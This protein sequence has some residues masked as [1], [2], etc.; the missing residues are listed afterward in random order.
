MVEVLV[1]LVIT[2]ILM[3][4]LIPVIGKAKNTAK[5]QSAVQNLRQLSVNLDL[6]RS[7]WNGSE[8][9]F[10]SYYSLGLPPVNYVRGEFS[11]IN[12]AILPSPCGLN[13]TAFNT[14]F[15]PGAAG[16]VSPVFATGDP[17]HGP[18]QAKEFKEHIPEYRENSVMFIDVNCNDEGVKFNEPY[19]LKR[20]LAVLFSGQL[21]N[22]SDKGH[23]STL[24]WYS[25]PASK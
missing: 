21:V 11:R 13:T 5:V 2:A 8:T 14:A 24:R 17:I 9:A 6:Y 7:D 4:I 3:G 23:A 19:T 10:D 1:V 18:T 16:H 25:Q 20:G 22:K 12:A 15:F